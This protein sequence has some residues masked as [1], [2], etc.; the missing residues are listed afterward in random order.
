L[1]A[2]KV[3]MENKLSEQESLELINRMIHTA[4]NNLQKGTGNL[5]L[6]WGYLVA[7]ISAATLILLISVTGPARYQAYYLWFLMVLGY[8]LHLILVRK[9]NRKTL[10][11]TYVDRIMTWVWIA[12]T[13]SVVAVIVGL[14]IASFS[15][16]SGSQEE[17]T[18]SDSFTRWFHWLF[19]PPF[20]LS[21]YGLALFVSGKAYGFK[22]LV[23]G[24]TVCWAATLVLLALIHQSHVLEIQQGVVFFSVIAGFIIPGHLLN[25]KEREDV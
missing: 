10:V 7:V 11:I 14:L 19:M 8:P 2:K 23:A 24:G 3:I 4:K 22:P 20:M 17:A 25:R 6:L 1:Q 12:F 15:G 5:F 21:L 13:L 9:I 18:V 16:L